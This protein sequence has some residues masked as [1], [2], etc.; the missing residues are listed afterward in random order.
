MSEKII[1][2]PQKTKWHKV[3]LTNDQIIVGEGAELENMFK[4]VF[5]KSSAPK[6]MALFK[7]FGASGNRNFYFSPGSVEHVKSLFELYSGFPCEA[8]APELLIFLA[9]HDD[10]KM[11]VLCEYYEKAQKEYKSRS[12]IGNEE[13]AITQ[14]FFYGKCCH[15]NHL[16]SY[17]HCFGDKKLCHIPNIWRKK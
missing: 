9:G 7:T 17:V 6:D 16:R 5:I 3:I 11:F 8:P 14:T 2:Y 1:L 15:N 4:D 10:A 12:M 13:C